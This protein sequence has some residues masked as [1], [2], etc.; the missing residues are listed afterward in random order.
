MSSNRKH[1]LKHD[2]K[3]KKNRFQTLV[4]LISRRYI[5][6]RSTSRSLFCSKP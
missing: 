1:Y 3:I 4:T 2:F 5:D 6:L